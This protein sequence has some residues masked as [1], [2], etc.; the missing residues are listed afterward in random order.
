MPAFA[1]TGINDKGRKVSGTISANNE[2]ELYQRLKGQ[3]VELLSSKEDKGGAGLSGLFGRKIENRDLVQMCLHLQQLQAAGVGMMEGLADVREST[4]QRRLRDI[5]SEVYQDVAEGSSLSAAFGKHPKVF[6]Q[7]FESL[8]AAGE[9]SGNL[10]ESFSEL[11]KHLK[12]IHEV[13]SK[14]KKAIRYPSFML[15]VMLGLFFFMMTVV[16]PQVVSFLEDSGGELPLVTLSLIA[17]S[18]FVQHWFLLCVGVPVGLIIA[19]RIAAGLSQ[20]MAYRLDGWKLKV[21]MIGPVLRK[22]ALSRFAHFFAT[23][24][25]SG[26]PILECLVTAQKVVGNLVLA[27]QLNNVH[28]A[29]QDGNPL[30]TGMRNTGEFPSL[31]IR[32]VKI[33]E[34]SGNL[35][36]TLENV[37]EFYDRDVNESVDAMVA[38]IEPSLTIFAGGMMAWIVVGVLGP[39]YSSFGKLGQ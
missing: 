1:Y 5:I 19:L 31:V 18:N 32:M 17:T 2:I 4:E 9:A 27:D 26:V 16:V 35:G 39:I 21:P 24:F 23:M 10:N 6:G 20:G 11:V 30:S 3:N 38:M 15:V 33:G 37:T 36:E 28:S 29:V 25:R 8:I 34:D 12:W 7:V 13:N 14:V 22:I